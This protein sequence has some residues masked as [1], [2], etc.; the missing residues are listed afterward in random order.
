MK[1]KFKTLSIA[2]WCF[3]A[4]LYS[5]INSM[6]EID[7]CKHIPSPSQDWRQHVEKN[8]L[9]GQNGHSFASTSDVSVVLTLGQD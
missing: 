2:T 5:E 6:D 9:P 7:N 1:N 3:V 8:H 4:A